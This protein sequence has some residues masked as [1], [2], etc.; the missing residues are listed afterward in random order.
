MEELA[1][2]IERV[3]RRGEGAEGGDENFD[4][5]SSEEEEE[6]GRSVLDVEE[7]LARALEE[8]PRCIYSFLDFAVNQG[9]RLAWRPRCERRVD[10][11]IT[12]VDGRRTRAVSI[13][14]SVF[15]WVIAVLYL[16]SFKRKSADVYASGKTADE[17]ER[18]YQLVKKCVMRSWRHSASF[19]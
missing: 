13:C 16:A 12:S 18:N 6:D 7:T 17:I 2:V 4:D 5:Y 14:T 11:E 8:S 10:L 9:G 3:R 15:A 1:D 19:N